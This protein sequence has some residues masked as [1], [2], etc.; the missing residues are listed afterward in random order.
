MKPTADEL[1]RKLDDLAR[2]LTDEGAGERAALV[3]TAGERLR[4]LSTVLGEIKRGI[5]EV[6]ETVG[7]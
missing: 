1:A 7:G 2:A 6:A 5:A 4:V 3:R